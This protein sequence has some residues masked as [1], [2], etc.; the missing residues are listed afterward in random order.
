MLIMKGER[1]RREEQGSERVK[2]LVQNGH[3]AKRKKGMD[4]EEDEDEKEQEEGRKEGW[5]AKE[6]S[7]F[8]RMR[9]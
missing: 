5:M 8:G 9:K 1:R 3:E 6:W 2:E 4:L 7:E